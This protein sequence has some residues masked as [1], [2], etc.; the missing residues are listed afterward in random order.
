[1]MRNPIG[2]FTPAVEPA[3]EGRPMPATRVRSASA[4]SH[5]AGGEPVDRHTGRAHLGDGRP[6]ASG[7]LA[8]ELDSH[9]A[10]LRHHC[11]GILGSS[12]EVDDAVQETLVRAWRAVDRFDGR[13]SLRT[14]LYAIATNVCLSMRQAPQRRA[15]P[16]GGAGDTVA[17]EA[18]DGCPADTVAEREAVRLAFVVAL[19]RLPPRQRAVLVL[20]DALGWRAAEVAELL[21]TTVVSVNSALQR[22][23]S[24]LGAERVAV[25]DLVP[26]DQRPGPRGRVHHERVA[27]CVV[28]LE[29]C[30]A[31]ALVALL[32]DDGQVERVPLDEDGR[33]PALPLGA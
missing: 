20:R 30:D 11:G 19:N 13:S 5:A 8:L 23:R 29:R 32:G 17:G 9:R 10:E 14:W 21:G 4:P 24:T 3:T 26:D 31:S 15:R 33:L 22:A 25:D 7:R 12:L 1:M 27:R 16:V 28:A 6:S 2:A 18:A